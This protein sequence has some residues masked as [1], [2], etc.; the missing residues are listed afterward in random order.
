MS[1][2]KHVSKNPPPNKK[3]TEIIQTHHPSRA[4]LF[5]ADPLQQN[6]SKVFIASCFPLRLLITPIT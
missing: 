5:A 3:K 2:V 6:F 1:K 4:G